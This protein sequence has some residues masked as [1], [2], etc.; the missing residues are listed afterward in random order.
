MSLR[1]RPLL[2]ILAAVL[3]A[4]CDP[5]GPSGDLFDQ[6]RAYLSDPGC[7]SEQP[8]LPCSGSLVLRPDRSAEF[9]WPGSDI[10]V[11]G[12][13]AVFGTLLVVGLDQGFGQVRFRVESALVLRELESGAPWRYV[14]PPPIDF[15]AS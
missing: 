11:R 5:T 4:G 2:L 7:V 1:Y 8:E 9:S 3:V 14:E 12:D 6:E 10:I 13:Y 15:P